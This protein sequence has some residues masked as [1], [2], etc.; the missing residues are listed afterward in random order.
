MK[1]NKTTTD[2]LPPTSSHAICRV[3][4][5]PPL[6]FLSLPLIAYDQLVHGNDGMSVFV[7]LKPGPWKRH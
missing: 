6:F 2:C 5:P 7:R 4:S 1:Y 3:Y